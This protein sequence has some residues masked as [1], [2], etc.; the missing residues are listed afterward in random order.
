MIGLETSLALGITNLVRMGNLSMMQLF[1]KMSLNPARLYKLE[2]GSIAESAAADLKYDEKLRREA[3]SAK[4]AALREQANQEIA[5]ML[6]EE[7]ADT[8]DKVLFELSN[9]MKNAFSRSDA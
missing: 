8:L 5:D 4:R 2:H 3:N 6:K 7:T 9:R 1:E